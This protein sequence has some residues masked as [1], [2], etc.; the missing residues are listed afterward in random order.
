M[1]YFK[2]KLHWK[3]HLIAF[4]KDPNYNFNDF[5]YRSLFNSSET[6]R[7]WYISFK[8]FG[9]FFSR[10]LELSNDVKSM[11]RL[12]IRIYVLLTCW[13]LVF[14]YLLAHLFEWLK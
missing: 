2:M 8:F 11:T 7:W 9:P 10:N 4:E 12:K 14:A 5:L 1:L 13:W 6:E 3:Y